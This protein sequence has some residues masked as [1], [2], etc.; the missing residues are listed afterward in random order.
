MELE[1]GGVNIWTL[2]H[3]YLEN[4]CGIKKPIVWN[5]YPNLTLFDVINVIKKDT[6]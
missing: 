5:R 3:Y 1:Q 6:K 2:V 4:D